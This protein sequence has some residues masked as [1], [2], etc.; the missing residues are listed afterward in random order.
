MKA[1]NLLRLLLMGITLSLAGC[2]ALFEDNLDRAYKSGNL[3]AKDYYSLKAQQQEARRQQM[4][5]EQQA[6]QQ[7]QD[8]T[9]SQAMQNLSQ[10]MRSA[11]DATTPMFS[12]PIVQ[13][14]P[15]GIGIENRPVHAQTESVLPSGLALD[16]MRRGEG[17]PTGKTRLGSDGTFWYEY[18]LYNGSTYW[19]PAQ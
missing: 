4:F 13:A 19:S 9:V 15:Q 3:T 1:N 18:R 11:G 16:Q 6:F 2:A 12:T 17:A 10:A 8:E 5:L 14:R 7:R